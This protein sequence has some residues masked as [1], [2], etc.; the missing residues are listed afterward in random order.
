MTICDR[1]QELLAALRSGNWTPELRA[2]LAACESC[3]DAAI[4]AEF[5]HQ[6]AATADPHVPPAGLVWWKAQLRARRESAQAAARPVLIAE[7]AA[8]IVALLG[9]VGAL[10]WLSSDS[11]LAALAGIVALVLLT[12]AAAGALL[13]AWSKK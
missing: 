6:A 1:E 12:T 2:H 11:T 4:T 8:A 13:F 7:R 3:A 5:L 9:A 10:A